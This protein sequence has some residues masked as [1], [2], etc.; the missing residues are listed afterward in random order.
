ML[1]E[2]AERVGVVTSTT[3]FN[4][5]LCVDKDFIDGGGERDGLIDVAG[6]NQHNP[7]VIRFNFRWFG[8]HDDRSASPAAFQKTFHFQSIDCPGDGSDRN[9]VIETEFSMSRKTHSGTE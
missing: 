8:L 9:A 7:A 4:F 3:G 5:P 1:E 2:R 6:I